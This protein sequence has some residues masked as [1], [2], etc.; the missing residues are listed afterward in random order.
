MAAFK[1]DGNFTV[2]TACGAARKSFP[3]PG[4]N[5]SFIVEQEF[6]QLFAN[7]TPL[8]L[9]T[10]HPTF[11]TAY[12]VQESPLQD[13]GGGVAKWT[14]TYA[15]IP[16]QRNE[17]E[18]FAY[19]Y[20]GIYG[21]VLAQGGSVTTEVDGRERFTESSLSRVQHDYFL[22]AS[23]Q[24]YETPADIP[25]NA[26]QAYYQSADSTLVTD[27]L[28][29]SPPFTTASSPTLTAYLALVSGGDEIV[30]EESR[31]TR[32]MG[33]IYERTTRYVIAK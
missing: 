13:L 1:V 24:D 17:Y 21:Y 16:A 5:T 14:R 7:F 25:V 19:Q 8:A 18:M 11:T 10:A 12:L 30:A 29:D 4:D 22:C 23:G 32:W 27:Y 9:N 15:T 28:T 20:I 31:L 33:N 3:I 2:A 6:M 26:A